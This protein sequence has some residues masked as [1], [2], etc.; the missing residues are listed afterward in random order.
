MN[1]SKE[2]I[3]SDLYRQAGEKSFKKFIIY[4]LRHP[5]FRFMFFLRLSAAS[6][7]YNPIGLVS[8]V[9]LKQMKVKY[10]I[11]IPFM[12]Q[13]GK[14]FRLNHYGGIIINQG[15]VIGENCNICQG[16]TLGHISR[17]KLKGSPTLGDRVWIGANTVIVGKIMIGNDVLI[18]PLSYVNFDVPDNA[19]VVGNP[20]QI[21][22][23]NSSAGYVKNLI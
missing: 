3:V 9:W 23:Y 4:L 17:G 14:G 11:Q 18:A 16:V 5:E 6:S 8:R 12:T 20:A 21:V 1:K 7:F 15:A 10:G 2:L 22:S 19:V 13:I